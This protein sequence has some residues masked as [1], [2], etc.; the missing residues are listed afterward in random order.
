MSTCNAA[1]LKNA[2]DSVGGFDEKFPSAHNEDRDLVWRVE[3]LGPVVFA[4]EALIIHPPRRESFG[5]IARRVRVFETDFLLYAKSPAKYRK[6]ISASPWRT[7]YFN[8]GVVQQLN[9]LK[10]NFRYLIKSFRPF[11]LLVGLGIILA[12]WFY[13]G[14]F[15]PK[16]WKAHRVYRPDSRPAGNKNLCVAGVSKDAAARH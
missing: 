10:S 16:Y 4:P 3:E 14:W 1:Y 15:F 6:Y 11:H 5:K 8:V 12:R 2:F 7:I 9:D 13:L